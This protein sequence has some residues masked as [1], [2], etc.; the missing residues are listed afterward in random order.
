M[1]LQLLF[2]LAEREILLCM[3]KLLIFVLCI[4]MVLVYHTRI[5]HEDVFNLDV[6]VFV[7]KTLSRFRLEFYVSI[8]LQKCQVT[9][10]TFPGVSLVSAAT[11]TD[12][13]NFIYL[14]QQK[15]SGSQRIILYWV[16]NLSNWHCLYC[17]EER[18]FNCQFSL[19]SILILYF[20][21]TDIS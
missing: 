1:F 7:K 18:G 6:A 2:F 11:I 21:C 16:F 20:H 8:L 13:Q 5:L 14:D 12:M 4:M 9:K 3:C 17:I 19:I 15:G 10:Y